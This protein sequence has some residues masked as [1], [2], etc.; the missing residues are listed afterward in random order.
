M[1]HI[2][3][4]KAVFKTATDT[5][6][7]VALIGGTVAAAS[8]QGTGRA[9]GAGIALAGLAAKLVSAATT[10]EAD[11]RCWDNLPQYISFASLPMPVGEHVVTFEFLDR[12]GAPIANLTKVITVN[13]TTADHYKVVFVCDQSTTPQTQ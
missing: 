10:P 8:S 13:V 3:G 1:D 9:I 11:T 12:S 4:N 7:N 6:G 2:L 5:A